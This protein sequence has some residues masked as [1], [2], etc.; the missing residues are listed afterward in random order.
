MFSGLTNIF[1]V[2]HLQQAWPGIARTIDGDHERFEST[3]FERFP[4]YYFTGDGK[5]YA[6]K[7]IVSKLSIIFCLF[8]CRF[9]YI[10]AY[11]DSDGY[12]WITGRTDDLLNVSGHLLSTAEIESAIL[13][14]KRIA[15]AASV[16]MPH[17]IKGQCICAFIVTK[18]GYNY[19]NN[20]EKDIRNQGMLMLLLLLLILCLFKSFLN[21]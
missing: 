15:E 16:P 4:G 12:Y 8:V 6:L 20:F 11:R 13:K 14:D 18:N 10:A 2:G 19:D 21:Y 17:S 3:Y 5:Y 9:V 1:F 7:T